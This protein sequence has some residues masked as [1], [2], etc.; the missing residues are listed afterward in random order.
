MQTGEYKEVARDVEVQMML[1][2]KKWDEVRNVRI[3]RSVSRRYAPSLSN[4]HL[5]VINSYEALQVSDDHGI[6][7]KEFAFFRDREGLLK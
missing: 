2:C 7:E 4:G 6:I 1:C 3:Q 5:A